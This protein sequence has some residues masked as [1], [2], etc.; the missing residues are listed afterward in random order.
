MQRLQPASSTRYQYRLLCAARHNTIDVHGMHRTCLSLLQKRYP[1]PRSTLH[2]Q[3]CTT[4]GIGR[5]AHYWMNQFNPI[6]R[7]TSMPSTNP[8]ILG[9][10]R[11]PQSHIFSPY[12]LH[13]K[14]LL[15][16]M[17]SPF[18]EKKQCIEKKAVLDDLSIHL[19]MDIGRIYWIKYRRF[20]PPGHEAMLF[21]RI[22]CHFPYITSV[23]WA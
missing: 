16:G 1:L 5:A 21:F 12:L 22:Q 18:N 10:G 4:Y 9:R 8:P 23:P 6:P 19:N 3:G 7:S 13:T 15:S 2:A 20:T 11:S 17:R 14:I